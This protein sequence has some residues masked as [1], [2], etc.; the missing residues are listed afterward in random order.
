MNFKGKK[1][2][3]AGLDKSGIG[4]VKYFSSRGANVTV[5]DLR[6]RLELQTALS[7][8]KDYEF[9][10]EFG[11]YSSKTFFDADMVHISMKAR[12]DD[13]ILNQ[14]REKKIPV[15]T[16]YE[17]TAPLLKN[18]VICIT[19]TNGKSSTAVMISEMLRN[20]GKKAFITGHVGKSIYEYLINEE[21]YDALL[22]EL[23]ADYFDYAYGF[24]FHSIVLLNISDE[25]L[26]ERSNS[27]QTFADHVTTYTDYLSKV[28][29]KCPLVYSRECENVFTVVS[30]LGGHTIPFSVNFDES[31]IANYKHGAVFVKDNGIVL[32]KP[33]HEQTYSIDNLKIR[34][35]FNKN[36]FMASV[37]VASSLGA[38]DV[39][40]GY[41]LN[42]FAGVEHRLEFVQKKNN[43]LFYNDARV[44][45]VKGLIRSLQSFDKAVILIS[46][47][48]D[49]GEEYDELCPYIEKHVKTL[50]LLGESKERMNR[51]I[52]DATE[53]FVVGTFEEAVILAYQ[54]SKSGDIILYSPG[55]LPSD[56]FT[57]IE[58]R[59]RHYKDIIKT[60]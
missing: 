18:P 36:N 17:F 42:N 54:K 35:E 10:A 1:V 14:A 52:G 38:T 47:G 21:D 2:V 30:R 44:S 13:R 12:H 9:K 41:V 34:G 19:G 60:F 27:W 55:C 51:S 48:K 24:N 4:A 46:G 15:K 26:I 29:G 16:E 5:A 8:V 23:D 58:E 33:R 49:R 31:D 57:K 25:K 56:N 59:G 53:T 7:I 28:A 22:L 37:W 43:V 32:K 39:S 6:N 3:I 20:S 45:T 11:R 40:V 50:I